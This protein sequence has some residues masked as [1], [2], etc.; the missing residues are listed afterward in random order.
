MYALSTYISNNITKKS[1]KSFAKSL[2]ESDYKDGSNAKEYI[3]RL[4]NSKRLTID[5]FNNYLFN[6]LFYGQ[7]KDVY[8][9]KIHKY[10]YNIISEKKL[11]DIISKEYKG[12]SNF[13]EISARVL[14][15]EDERLELVACKTECN[16]ENG[17]VNNIKLL[18]AYKIAKTNNKKLRIEEHSYVPVEIDL[19]RRLLITKVAPKTNLEKDAYKPD[20]LYEKYTDKIKKM[21]SIE[22][23]S[24]DISHK[25]AL[26]NM[27]EVLYNQVYNKMISTKSNNLEKEID[28]FCT[29]IDKEIKIKNIEEK[30]KN[31]NIF[32][33]NYSI[34]KFF[35]QLLITDI[36][37]T[38]DVEDNMNG[39][40]GLV[41][42]LRFNDGTNVS[43][44]VRGENCRAC[45]YTSETYLALRDPI[46]NSNK[47][48]EM[49]VV[50]IGNNKDF[51]V[52]Y[53]T[54]SYY[55]LFMHFYEDFKKDDF[56]YGYSKYKEYESMGI[57]EVR[58]MAK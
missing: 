5:G 14:S 19:I 34:K 54:N 35:N 25:K 41:T 49:N 11:S 8:V 1:L 57:S 51:R 55:Y 28:K 23:N 58:R 27:S 32:D 47:I 24:Y 39:I 50:W 15:N 42:Y 43:A 31:N 29:V 48:S 12:N 17:E 18:F 40:D 10:D 2:N 16:R 4:I 13:N 45:I 21:F 6:E 52:K 36:L 9:H 33:I 53:A 20:T 38:N 22:L 30:K 3:E 26:Y 44:K 46:E 37:T 7:Q 56:N